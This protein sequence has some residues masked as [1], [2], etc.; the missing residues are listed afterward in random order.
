MRARRNYWKSDGDS[1]KTRKVILYG[2]VST[3]GQV[4]NTSLETQLARLTEEAD[5]RGMDAI[6][7]QDG[8][9]SAKNTDRPAFSEALNLLAQGDA[10][11]LMVTKLDR[12]SRNLQDVLHLAERAEREGWDIVVLDGSVKF[13]SGTPNGKLQLRLIA[14]LAEWE[15]DTIRQRVITGIERQRERGDD[16]YILS[17]VEAHIIDLYR[18]GLSM[19][20]IAERLNAEGVETAKGGRWYASTIKRVTDR[21]E[22][23]EK[24]GI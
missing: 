19:N 24:E 11:V 3:E 20:K 4:H 10:Q 17:R 2:R 23:R 15:R 21:A 22:R 12:L 8:G 9:E 5:R 18:S 13:D 1:P 7:L 14:S 16:G 6:I